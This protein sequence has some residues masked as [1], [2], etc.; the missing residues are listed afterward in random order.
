MARFS[1]GAV[2]VVVTVVLGVL[3]ATSSVVE[4]GRPYAESQSWLV[5]LVGVALGAAAAM[6]RASALPRL[7][8]ALSSAAWLLGSLSGWLLLAHQ[9]ALLLVL[10]AFPTRGRIE[11]TDR[12]VGVLAVR[13][14]LGMLA[15]PVVGFLFCA[16]AVDRLRRRRTPQHIGAAAAG[17]LVG[18]SLLGSWLASRTDEHG[19][20]PDTALL[21]YEGALVAAA[22]VLVLGSG[23][24]KSLQRELVDRLVS[25]SGEG[26]VP[27]LAAVLAD[28]LHARGLTI[29]G[30][31][32]EHPVLDSLGDATREGVRTAV[33][34]VAQ[35]DERRR[36]LDDQIDELRAAQRRMISA[37]DEQRALTAGL[38]RDE[39]VAPLRFARQVLEREERPADQVA[40]GS[41]DT[42][43]DQIRTAAD[44]V[45]KIVWGAGPVRLG[46]GG[47]AEAIRS[48][49]DLSPVAVEVRISGT[50]R[51]A[52]E[53]EAAACFVCAEALVNV[54]RHARATRTVV[55]L[56]R[57]AEGSPDC[58][59]R[60]RRWGG[61]GRSG[62][63]GWPIG[64]P[65]T[66]VGSA[67]T[68]HPE[69]APWS[70]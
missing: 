24:A 29:N 63:T 65:C 2:T 68:V 34:L 23:A 11:G 38:L 40:A 5:P 7:L 51:A 21:W 41:L 47:L 56:A 70:T 48:M 57:A 17:A 10:L 61:P 66:E 3:V 13:V 6:L 43:L 27:A 58:L 39:V 25:G 28:L 44:D 22:G 4:A 69:P 59:G 9:G 18:L 14:A 37:Q 12:W 64:L 50:A 55:M 1:R 36:A 8:L 45:E 67:W 20:E 26:G 53:V 54:H 19:F 62:L 35:S 60:R 42:A 16:V 46:A 32:V 33:R 31:T 30:T 49:A 15:Q 52:P